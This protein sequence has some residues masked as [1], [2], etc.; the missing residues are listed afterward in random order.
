MLKSGLTVCVRAV[1]ACAMAGA[2]RGVEL[3]P[4]LA[5]HGCS[6]ASLA[7]P[8]VRVPH[9]LVVALWTEVPAR[10]HDDAFGLHAAEASLNIAFDAIDHAVKNCATVAESMSR[11]ARY[12]RL[13]HDASAAAV[14]VHGEVGRYTQRFDCVPRPPR[15]LCEF[16]LARWV[17]LLR[18]SFGEAVPLRAIGFMHEAP[19][20]QREHQRVL[21]LPLRFGEPQLLLEFHRSLLT[22]S[23]RG[24]DPVLGEMM[25]RHVEDLLARLGDKADLLQAARRVFI[26]RLPD[27]PP[28]IE[29]VARALGL[30][31]RSLQRRLQD[32]GTTFQALLDDT[33]RALA[34]ER[35][36]NPT[37]TL[38]EVALLA[39]FADASSFHHA[40]RRWTGTTPREHRLGREKAELP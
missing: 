31:R 6:L 24:T 27:G 34:L 21:G 33:R 1:Q 4:I 26:E 28:R 16:I 40:F 12:Q 29:A 13:L 22:L 19:A 38:T 2:I 14:E 39:G 5:A 32:E 11:M 25:R 18:R 17:L 23:A 20:D 9:E 8:Y 37:T 15:H 36:R 3:G 35:L 7:D 10:L 30:S